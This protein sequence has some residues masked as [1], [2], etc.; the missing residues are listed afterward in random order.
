MLLSWL[1]NTQVDLPQPRHPRS[2]HLRRRQPVGSSPAPRGRCLAT[3]RST[4][5]ACGTPHWAGCAPRCAR[6][7]RPMRCRRMRAWGATPRPLETRSPGRD[8]PTWEESTASRVTTA[9]L[10]LV[11]V[12]F[13]VPP[14]AHSVPLHAR[15][16]RDDTA[17]AAVLGVPDSGIVS[18][19]MPES[20]FHSARTSVPENAR[21]GTMAYSR[22]DRV[23]RKYGAHRRARGHGRSFQHGLAFRSPAILTMRGTTRPRW[24]RPGRERTHWFASRAWSAWTEAP[25]RAQSELPGSWTRC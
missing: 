17:L 5:R 25:R 21:A 9:A 8:C 15:L 22:R 14:A 20:V 24:C 4:D 2:T 10:T 18:V 23:D 3:R 7:V 11:P 12:T 16:P 13:S 1:V 6:R 19:S